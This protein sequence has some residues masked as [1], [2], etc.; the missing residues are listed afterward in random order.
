MKKLFTLSIFLFCLTIVRGQ[1]TF[2]KGYFIDNDDKRTECLIQDVTWKSPPYLVYQLPGK[3]LP[4]TLQPFAIKE[5][6]IDR[7]NRFISANVMV[8][9]SSDDERNLSVDGEPQ[10]IQTRIFLNVLVEGDYTLYYFSIPTM[11][12]FFYSTPNTPLQQLV[13]KKFTSKD[14]PSL[15]RQNFYFRKQL[16]NDVHVPD[17][18]VF[19]VRDLEYER[20]AL[21]A[22]FIKC[23]SKGG[24]TFEVRK[25]KHEN[26]AFHLRVTPGICFSSLST[27]GYNS[28]TYDVRFDREFGFRF[29]VEPELIFPY[30]NKQL[31]LIIEPSFH[32]YKSSGTINWQTLQVQF[33]TIEFPIGLRVHFFPRKEWSLFADAFFVPT[34][35]TVNSYMHFENSTSPGYILRPCIAFGGG[36]TWKRIGM[37]LRY[38]TSQKPVN[39]TL[40]SAK[41]TR[42]A[43]VIGY[44]IF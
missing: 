17:I 21:T 16:L 42:A 30:T 11:E 15:L 2:S 12:R 7:G 14:N 13:Y 29:G 43:I 26:G 34:P 8:D 31:G 37:E 38:Y 4:D 24:T 5:F 22:F 36:M 25:R 9:I 18:T 32:Y 33:Y 23:N 40:F 10:W 3:S 6:G 35:L 39:N 1:T 20:E 28:A 41:Y 19:S 27:K 44:R